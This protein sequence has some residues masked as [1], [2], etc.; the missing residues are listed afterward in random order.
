MLKC[1]QPIL[2]DREAY[3]AH[4]VS[5][6]RQGLGPTAPNPCVGAVL[7]SDG[8]IVAQGFHERFGQPHAEVR[9]LAD[10]REKGVDPSQCEMFVTLE[11][12]NHYGKTPPC[13]RAV[14]DAGIRSIAIG[15]LD[16]NPDVAG[17]GAAFLESNGVR[18]EV[19]LLYDECR[20]LIDDFLVWKDTKRPYVFL[21]MATTLD[22]RIACRNGHS[23]YVTGPLSRKRVHELR[24]RVGAVMIG[25]GTLRADNPGLDVR[26]NPMPENAND[27]LAVIVTSN[28]PGKS[29]ALKLLEHRPEKTI[30]FTNNTSASHPNA[31]RLTSM[32]VRVIALPPATSEDGNDESGLNL[33]FGLIKLRQE[34]GVHHVLC[35]GGGGLAMSLFEAGLVDETLLFQA[36]KI[37]G[38]DQAIPVFYGRSPL[39][40][41]EALPVRVTSVQP[42]GDD[43]LLTLKRPR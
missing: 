11:P 7:V 22:G 17:G 35:E 29:A 26:L 31:T 38:D 19:G 40:M 23:S 15:C 16:P 27:P 8:R 1:S 9:C 28:L 30:F 3:M 32:G 12:C 33:E 13:T 2:T 6:A 39:Q 34:Y 4:A 36:P 42:V 37:L 25:G 14:F 41:D 21:K 5:L 18:V 24:A 10:A 43:F 20:D